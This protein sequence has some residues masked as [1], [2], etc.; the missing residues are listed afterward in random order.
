MKYTLGFDIGSSSVK[1]S[2]LDIE[3]GTSAGTAFFPK[4]EMTIS[5]HTDEAPKVSGHLERKH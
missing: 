2:L 5:I 3:K 1:V 4:K